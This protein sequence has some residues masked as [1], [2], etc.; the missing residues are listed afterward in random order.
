[1][2]W[3]PKQID[4]LRKLWEEGFSFKE[5][6]QHFAHGCTRN[7][8]AGKITRLGLMKSHNHNT[9]REV[10]LQRTRRGLACTPKPPT[11]T[12]TTSRV[13]K[14]PLP[15]PP[16]PEVTVLAPEVTAN[17]KR[18]PVGSVTLLERGPDQCCFPV[19]D[20]GPFLFCG[21]PKKAGSPYCKRHY[22]LMYRPASTSFRSTR[23]NWGF[24]NEMG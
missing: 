15:P 17:V 24:V 4:E 3:G 5:I 19:N 12:P 22:K 16:A 21:A 9:A 10:R 20:G 6:A 2:Q 14:T 18:T 7:M 23:V 1:M 8:V 11:P 13:D